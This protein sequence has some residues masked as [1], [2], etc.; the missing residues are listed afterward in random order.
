MSPNPSD[1]RDILGGSQGMERRD[2]VKTV[3]L[4]AASIGLTSAATTEI[5]RAATTGLKPS[6]VWLHFQ[7]CT[8]CTESL[9][10]T[11][12]SRARVS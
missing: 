9:L 12:A 3:T 11:S 4:A 1:F 7:E 5:V 8:G 10:R 2:F 6:V